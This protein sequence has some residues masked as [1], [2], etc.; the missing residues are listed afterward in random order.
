MMGILI[1]MVVMLILHI[2]TSYWYWIMVVPFIYC[3]LKIKTGWKGFCFGATSAGLLWLIASL[4]FWLSAGEI[5][6]HRIAEMI[7]VGSPGILVT[8]TTLI[9][10]LAGGCAGASGSLLRNVLKKN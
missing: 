5:I 3:L 8:F 6:T 1:G 9:A 2:L 4:Y 10:I 7:K